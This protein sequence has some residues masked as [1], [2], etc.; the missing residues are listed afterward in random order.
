MLGR[1]GA[2]TLA[3]SLWI[4]AIAGALP[5]ALHASAQTAASQIVR[6]Q[7]NESGLS[8]V[9]LKVGQVEREVLFYT[10]QSAAPKAPLVIAFHGGGATSVQAFARRLGLRGM[11]ERYG[12]IIALPKGTAGPG[13]RMSWTAGEPEGPGGARRAPADDLGF[14]DA[15]IATALATNRVDPDRIYAMGLSK[16]GMMSYWAACN[17]PGQ[18]AAIAV[19][20]GTLASGRCADPGGTS[21]L[22]I[23]GTADENV[24]FE[25]GRGA[26]TAHGNTWASARDGIAHFADGAAC[27]PDWAPDQP[28]GDTVCRSVDC[29]GESSVTYCLVANGGHGWPGAAPTPRQMRQGG[30]AAPNSASAFV[31]TDYI[32]RFFLAH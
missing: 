27:S 21:L 26:R 32:A 2:L 9:P 20:A 15:V 14:V 25:G 23:H 6:V 3:A 17:R 28:A 4:G 12:F 19:V 13:G 16:G 8:R 7:A 10:P 31:A 24:P 5:T 22:H 29:P 11:A 1:F 18:F 30:A